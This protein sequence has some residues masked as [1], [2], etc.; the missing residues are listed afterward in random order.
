MENLKKINQH[1]LEFN[2]GISTYTQGITAFTD[3]VFRK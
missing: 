3:L 2:Q 1:N